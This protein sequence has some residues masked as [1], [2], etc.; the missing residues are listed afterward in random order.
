M[1]RGKYARRIGK[2]K[3]RIRTR[4]V[5][6]RRPS[7]KIGGGRSLI[8]TLCNKVKRGIERLR[9]K[10]DVLKRAEL[11]AKREL[12]KALR[13][14][15][16]GEYDEFLKH[17]DVVKRLGETLRTLRPESTIYEWNV[18]PGIFRIRKRRG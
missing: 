6:K 10:P 9:R 7:S 11:A 4:P 15:E 14:A 12:E 3:G 1:G 5:S 2:S 13:A 8:R 18:I 17:V 16:R